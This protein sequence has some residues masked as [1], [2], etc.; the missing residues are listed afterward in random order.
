M[1]KFIRMRVGAYPSAIFSL[2]IRYHEEEYPQVWGEL[3]F[4][5]LGQAAI[6]QGVPFEQATST[7]WLVEEQTLEA[8]PERFVKQCLTAMGVEG[9][10]EDD[11]EA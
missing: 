10:E 3:R 11:P 7:P 4:S 1:A 9:F 6:A 5:D 8:D 2:Y